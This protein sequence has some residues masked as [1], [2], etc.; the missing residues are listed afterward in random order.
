MKYGSYLLQESMDSRRFSNDC[1]QTTTKMKCKTSMF[2]FKVGE[3]KDDVQLIPPERVTP[4]AP[5]SSLR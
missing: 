5:Q 3:K 4:P 1:V 2:S